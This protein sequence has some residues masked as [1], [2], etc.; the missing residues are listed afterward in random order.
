MITLENYKTELNGICVVE[1]SGEGCA[2]CISMMHL[3]SAIAKDR[4]DLTLKHIEASVE[5][6]PLLE[7]FEVDRVPTVLLTDNGEVFARATGYQPEEILEIWI[8]AKIE[9][10]KGNTL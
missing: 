8:D 5:T 9:E 10:H 6:M 4:S 2:N 3:L 7:A 1:V